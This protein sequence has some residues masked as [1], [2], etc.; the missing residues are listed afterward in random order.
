M[1]DKWPEGAEPPSVHHADDQLMKFTARYKEFLT[2]RGSVSEQQ[3]LRA[4]LSRAL[5]SAYFQSSEVSSHLKPSQEFIYKTANINMVESWKKTN[6]D[7]SFVPFPLL[8]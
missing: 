3:Q 1:S 8:V 6:R 4:C 2:E 7:N 5:I